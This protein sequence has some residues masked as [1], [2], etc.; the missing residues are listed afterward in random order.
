M[1][2]GGFFLALH[3]Y[4]STDLTPPARGIYFCVS[5]NLEGKPWQKQWFTSE[6]KTEQRDYGADPCGFCHY[7][8]C[9]GTSFSPI[10]KLK[11]LQLLQCDPLLPAY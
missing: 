7:L 1:I 5:C 8:A 9:M 11:S 10:W 2:P 6:P 3:F 4:A